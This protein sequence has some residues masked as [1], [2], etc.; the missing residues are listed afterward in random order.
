MNKS[1]RPIGITALAFVSVLVG[2][3]SQVAALA[4]LIGGVVFGLTGTASTTALVVIGAVYFGLM[5]A[6][7]LVG[8]GLWMQ[9]RWSWAGGLV[10]F[11]VLIAVSFFTALV[12]G[13]TGSAIVP[14]VGAAVAIAYLFLPATRARLLGIETT[15][16]TQAPDEAGTS[17]APAFDATPSA[18]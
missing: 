17:D 13:N 9:R 2:L 6:A 16:R 4:L 14:M 10:V 8:F 12:A 11:G 7:Y 5:V 15:E 3:Y 1:H 18:R